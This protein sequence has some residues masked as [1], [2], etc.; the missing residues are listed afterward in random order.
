MTVILLLLVVGFLAYRIM[1]PEERA[2]FFQRALA[3]VHRVKEQS[4][5]PRPDYD[6]FRSALRARNPRALATFVLVGMNVAV[7]AVMAAGAGSVS[8]PQTLLG[9][10]GNFGPWTTNMQWWRLV[11]SMFV[12]TGMLHLLVNML[13]L[14]QLG[15]MLERLVGRVSFVGAYLAAGIFASLISVSVYPVDVSVG[16]SGAVFGLYGLVLGCGIWI[17]LQRSTGRDTAGRAHPMR[18]NVPLVAVTRLVPAATLCLLYNAF[19]GGLAFT[20]EL[21]GLFAGFV[22]GLFLGRGVVDCEPPR[23]RVF[24]VMTAASAI[25]IF[26]A[27]PLGGLVDVRPEIRR[28]VAVEDRTAGTYKTARDQFNNG[29]ISAK[30][31]ADLIDRR[32]VPELKAAEQRLKALGRV[33]QEHLPLVAEAEE[34]LRLR[35]ESWRL[36]AEGL[37]EASGASR[38]Q[39]RMPITLEASRLRA[40][41]QH[42]ASSLALGKAEGTER[43]SLEVLQ[44]LK[45]AQDRTGSSD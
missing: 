30:A 31:L 27:T 44:R 33:P 45:T 8:D 4:K 16:A 23:R 12:H 29:Q 35:S 17:Q 20:A 41:A 11:T 3:D 7:F 13:S 10:G 15:V 5:R 25:A 6:A 38:R 40:E 32:I 2:R 21:T 18:V 37:R 28:L 36:R 9:W 14:L 24:A 1:K 42:R 43:A 26:M 39:T 19:N 22:C 34:Y